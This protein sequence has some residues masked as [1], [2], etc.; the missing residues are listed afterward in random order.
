MEPTRSGTITSAECLTIEEVHTSGVGGSIPSLMVPVKGNIESK[1]FR[2]TFVV[3]VSEETAVIAFRL[4]DK[5][6]K[7][8]K[9][10]TTDQRDPNSCQWRANQ[11]WVCRRYGR[12]GQREQEA[13]R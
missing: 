10:V 12:Y 13:S 11:C 7:H 2:Q 6:K 1:I 3:A 4:E 9:E 5:K 8:R